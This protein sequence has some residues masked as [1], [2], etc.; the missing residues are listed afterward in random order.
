[1]DTIPSDT[2]EPQPLTP[3]MLLTMKT[4]P[5]MPLQGRFVQQDLYAC[6]WWRRAQYPADQFWIRW[7]LQHLEN[8][9]S[10]SKWQN[11]ER[12]LSVSDIVLVKEENAHRNDRLLGK[13]VEVTRSADDRVRSAKVATARGGTLLTYDHPICS[14]LLLLKNKEEV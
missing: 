9:Q 4:R 11:R 1:M 3:T 12:N 13:I 8:L 7:R 14:F 2:D 10:Q 5:L 6:N